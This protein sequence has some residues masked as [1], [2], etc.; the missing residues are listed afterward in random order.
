MI[1]EQ[2]A[3]FGVTRSDI[4]DGEL[5]P[6]VVAALEAWGNLGR[7]SWLE[8]FTTTAVVEMVNSNAIVSGGGYSD[9]IRQKLIAELGVKREALKSE[10]VHVE[11]D[12]EHVLIFDKVIP[13]YVTRESHEEMVLNAAK[14]ALVIKRAFRGGMAAAMQQCS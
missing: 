13:R 5:N 1:V 12:Q 8:S 3:S 7:R 14:K 6:F 2:A 9:R 4:E 10:N 11:A